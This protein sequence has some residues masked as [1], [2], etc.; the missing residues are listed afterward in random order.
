[1]SSC[2]NKEASTGTPI[3]R[4]SRDRDGGSKV[5]SSAALE[6]A[7]GRGSAQAVDTFL[8]ASAPV[9]NR[10]PATSAYSPVLTP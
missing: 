4:D 1:M 2:P 7:T 10:L 6:A 8:S 3:W 5:D 9:S